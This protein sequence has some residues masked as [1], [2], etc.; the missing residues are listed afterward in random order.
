MKS[1]FCEQLLHALAGWKWKQNHEKTVTFVTLDKPFG[2]IGLCE[3]WYDI[4]R[5]HPA[6]TIH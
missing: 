6:S 4:F 2:T 3:S 1:F 5:H